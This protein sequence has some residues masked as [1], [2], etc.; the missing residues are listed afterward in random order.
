VTFP[1]SVLYALEH[2]WQYLRRIRA[3]R[4]SSPGDRSAA[5]LATLLELLRETSVD[6]VCAQG[7]HNVLLRTIDSV[8]RIC[9]AIQR[10]F[11]D[12]ALPAAFRKPSVA[13]ARDS[14]Q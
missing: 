9:D 10:D 12:P 3:E 7:V 2:A 8:A 11:F 1:R 14:A 13:G 4:P 5:L 6:E